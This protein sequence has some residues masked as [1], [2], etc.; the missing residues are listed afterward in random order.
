MGFGGKDLQCAHS[1]FDLEQIFR[2]QNDSLYAWSEMFMRNIGGTNSLKIQEFALDFTAKYLQGLWY[3]PI[4]PNLR[5]EGRIY[6]KDWN[7]QLHNLANYDDKHMTPPV[8]AKHKLCTKPELAT[9][10]Y[11][12]PLPEAESL[13]QIVKRPINI[14]GYTS[15][16]RLCNIN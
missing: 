5:C 12:D 6:D 10:I 13:K 4:G 3:K 8:Y 2:S 16:K 14:D 1:K 15:C 7:L 9:R 11:S